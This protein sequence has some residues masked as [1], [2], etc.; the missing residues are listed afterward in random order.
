MLATVDNQLSLYLYIRCQFII[1]IAVT[2]AI[3]TVI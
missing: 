3:G 2:I 1:E